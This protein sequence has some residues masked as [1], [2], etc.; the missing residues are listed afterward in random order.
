MLEDDEKEVS[1]IFLSV[2]EPHGAETRY[3][4]D[5]SAGTLYEADSVENGT[6]VYHVKE[7]GF[8]RLVDGDEI[9]ADKFLRP[10]GAAAFTG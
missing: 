10:D 8:D 7:T 6:Q 1:C 9:F 5:L 3:W 2:L 4:I